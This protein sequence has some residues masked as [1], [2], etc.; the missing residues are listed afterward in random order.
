MMTDNTQNKV[1]KVF[2]LVGHE[3]FGKSRTLIELTGSNNSKYEYEI[4]QGLCFWLSRKSNDDLGK[5][6]LDKVKDYIENGAEYMLLAF[7]PFFSE[8]ENDDSRY[9]RQILNTL[10]KTGYEIYAFILKDS[11]DGAQHIE[12]DE[13]N[14]LRTYCKKV[15]EITS[16]GAEKRAV[17][18]KHFIQEN[19]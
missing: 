7:C 6:L 13:I 9:T 4:V 11:W 2:L 14:I 18:L 10:R 16:R 12:N 1:K 17:E 3:N 8:N 19:T 5:N 15:Q